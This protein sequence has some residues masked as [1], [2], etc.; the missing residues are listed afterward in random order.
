MAPIL[1]PAESIPGYLFGINL[2]IPAQICDELSWG[3]SNVYGRTRPSPA[4]APACSCSCSGSCSWRTDGQTDGQTQA[5]IIPL[6]PE[7]PSGKIQTFYSMK[8]IWILDE[9]WIFENIDSQMSVILFRSQ[10][11]SLGP[12]IPWWR[13]QM[14]TFS[15]LLT[16]CA[17]NS[18]GTGE[19]PAQRPVTRSFDVFFDL[20]PN[21]RL[22]KQSWGWWF[23]TP[24]P[25]LWRHRNVK[26]MPASVY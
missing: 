8:Y 5:T 12:S 26:C 20:R 18:P 6:R 9:F 25:P 7:R 15:A 14:E 10:S 13:H 17:G 21:K 11:G 1:I 22:S 4:P 3:K 16:I 23:E 24:S 19:F 2:V